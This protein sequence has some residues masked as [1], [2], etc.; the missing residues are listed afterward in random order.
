MKHELLIVC[1]QGF[2]SPNLYEENAANRSPSASQ[3]MTAVAAICLHVVMN[4]QGTAIASAL[5]SANVRMV[6]AGS[7][8]HSRS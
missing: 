1:S 7:I 5:T 6:G 2:Q 8:A 3:A 4:V